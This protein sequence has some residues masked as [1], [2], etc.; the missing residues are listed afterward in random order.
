LPDEIAVLRARRPEVFP[1]LFRRAADSNLRRLWMSR[2]SSI[3][4]LSV[5][6]ALVFLAACS[7]QPAAPP[8]T[9]AADEAA[10]RAATISW[11]NAAQAKD[12]DKAVSL[13]A[14]D[15]LQFA[16]K[17]P[18]VRGKDNIRQGWQQMFALPGPGLRFATSGV[19]VARSGD[20]AYEYGTYDFATKDKKGNIN[21]QKGKYVTVWKK[22]A[23]GSWKVAVDIDNADAL[24]APP[25]APSKRKPATH[26]RR[27]R[28]S[29]SA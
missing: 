14:D 6:L 22:Q 17:G 26:K 4:S 10:I 2:L 23:D 15:A 20:I 28:R 13:Y 1:Y 21:D 7:K 24:P 9:R 3:L 16:D 11:S 27:R 29:A 18:L 19:E 12:V 5:L 25:P 8:D